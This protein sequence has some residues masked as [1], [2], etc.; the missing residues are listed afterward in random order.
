MHAHLSY[1]PVVKTKAWLK[2]LEINS[3]RQRRLSDIAFAV[4]VERTPILE[5]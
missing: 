1:L 4:P 3:C 2:F 5:T